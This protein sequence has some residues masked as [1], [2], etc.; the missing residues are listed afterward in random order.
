VFSPRF[1]TREE[2]PSC[3]FNCAEATSPASRPKNR[4][5][6]GDA[7]GMSST[8]ATIDVVAADDGA[9]EFLC[10]VVQLIGRLGTTEHAKCARAVCLNFALKAFRSPLQGFVPSCRAVFAIFADEGSCQ[11]IVRYARHNAPPAT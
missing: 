3:F 2:Y 8:V 10:D 9:D 5:Q 7:W 11:P 4:R 1:R 6:T